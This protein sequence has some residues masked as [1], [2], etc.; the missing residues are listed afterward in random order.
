MCKEFERL[1][2]QESKS[3][4]FAALGSDPNSGLKVRAVVVKILSD[5]GVSDYGRL[6]VANRL[7]DADAL[8]LAQH[9]ASLG[10][11]LTSDQISSDPLFTEMAT[12]V[13]VRTPPR[14]CAYIPATSGSKF[15]NFVMTAFAN[16]PENVL[17]GFKL[18]MSETAD[19]VRSRFGANGLPD[20]MEL[21]NLV[22]KNL[23]FD[24][25]ATEDNAE[26]VTSESIHNAYINAA[27]KTAVERSVRGLVSEEQAA[28]GA[29]RKDDGKVTDIVK[30][31]HPE[32]AQRLMAAQSPAEV[33][34][35]C[36]E[37]KQAV[38]DA[39]KAYAEINEARNTVLPRAREAIAA[40]M[41]I[42]TEAL[43]SANIDL[44]GLESKANAL[45]EKIC[46]GKTDLS[47]KADYEKAFRDLADA[48]VAER[49][50]RLDAT[51]ALDMPQGV[52]D[53][54]KVS[55]LTVQKVK[56][57]DIAFLAS[58]AKKIDAT[59]LESALREGAPKER[60]YEK[61]RGI[62]TAIRTAVSKMLENLDEVG[63]DDLDGPS[64]IMIQMVVGSRPGLASLL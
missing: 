37:Y 50:S 8:A 57:T 11:D 61:M 41:G 63:P 25:I 20:G 36:A 39:G 7:S 43:A 22:A 64:T 42:T 52:K 4:F 31:R 33:D 9:L 53:T 44:S 18:L 10:S 26:R 38:R 60:I 35:I 19:L 34:A 27:V 32:L 54:V 15:N 45:A 46:N 5:S 24:F 56:H 29:G 14:S 12:K 16:I 59:E 2:T 28:A 13:P 55:L 48:F 51:D 23:L 1:T 3:A 6:S 40:R 21:R 47:T 49:M 58:E 30:A 62:S 17:P